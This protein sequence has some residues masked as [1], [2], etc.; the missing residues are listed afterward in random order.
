MP[1]KTAKATKHTDLPLE[2][3]L[4]DGSE[5]F[6]TLV[7][8][9]LSELEIEQDLFT[10]RTEAGLSQAA[11]AHAAG[12]SQPFIAKLESGNFKNFE[13]KTLVRIAAALGA[14]VEIRIKKPKAAHKTLSVTPPDKFSALAGRR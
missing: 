10:L 2:N 1:V 14:E 3:L 9:R 12:V 8:K 5:E 7:G 4:H 11:L 6:E 13:L